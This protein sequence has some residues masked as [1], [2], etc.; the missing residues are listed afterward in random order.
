MCVCVRVKVCLVCLVCLCLCL[1][2]ACVSVRGVC[3]WGCYTRPARPPRAPPV[4]RR[5]A[6][7]PE[8][9]EH[10]LK[11]NHGAWGKLAEFQFARVFVVDADAM[12]A[13]A[14]RFAATCVGG[15]LGGPGGRR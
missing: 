2:C 3:A 14:A 8:I 12:K 1:L 15:G 11:V 10:L 13:Q 4:T 6:Q 7:V 9:R 5:V